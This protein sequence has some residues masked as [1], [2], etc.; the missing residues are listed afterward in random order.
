M[1]KMEIFVSGNLPNF[2]NQREA[3]GLINVPNDQAS[4]LLCPQLEH[5]GTKPGSAPSYQYCLS[6]QVVEVDRYREIDLGR[7]NDMWHWNPVLSHGWADS[8][9]S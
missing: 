9:D 6:F 8:W 3:H 7:L 1:N 2:G 5:G 4:M